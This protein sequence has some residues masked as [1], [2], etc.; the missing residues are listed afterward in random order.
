M[1][2]TGILV[3]NTQESGTESL[4]V[5]EVYFFLELRA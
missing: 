2:E 3:V 4:S 1:P 5:L